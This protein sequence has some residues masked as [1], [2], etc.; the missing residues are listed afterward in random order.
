MLKT[1]TAD[2]RS[3]HMSRH[4]NDAL[5]QKSRAGW[6][7]ARLVVNQATRMMSI[8]ILI[9]RARERQ[10]SISAILMPDASQGGRVSIAAILIIDRAWEVM[11][12]W[13]PS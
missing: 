13:P 2:S 4:W 11:A 8:W 7:V 5:F 10:S 9:G 12:S 1:K 6:Q 3:G